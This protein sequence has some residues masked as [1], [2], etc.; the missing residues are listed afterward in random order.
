MDVIVKNVLGWASR[1][2]GRSAFTGK[3]VLVVSL[4]AALALVSALRHRPTRRAI[5]SRPVL[6]PQVGIGSVADK[7]RDGRLTDEPSL[8][9]ALSAIDPL[10]ALGPAVRQA[11]Y[12]HR[13]LN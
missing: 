12:A 8:R 13:W 7:I 4:S 2:L 9:F 5:Q 11:E 1:P 3:A 6:A 10:I